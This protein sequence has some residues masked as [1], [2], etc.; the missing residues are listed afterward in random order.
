MAEYGNANAI[1][2]NL[3]PNAFA[4]KLHLMI[5]YYSCDHTENCTSI[6][7]QGFSCPKSHFEK[8]LSRCYPFYLQAMQKWV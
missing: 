4:R 1:I 5:N 7:A 2:R 6:P 8:K 3:R